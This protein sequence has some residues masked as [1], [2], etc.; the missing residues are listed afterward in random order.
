MGGV[1]LVLHHASWYNHFGSG[2]AASFRGNRVEDTM[3]FD[4]SLLRLDCGQRGLDQPLDLLHGT[5][6]GLGWVVYPTQETIPRHQDCSFRLGIASIRLLAYGRLQLGGH[7]SLHSRHEESTNWSACGV[8]SRKYTYFEC[9]N[10]S[11]VVSLCQQVSNVSL[12]ILA[13]IK[14]QIASS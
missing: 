3:K 1:S 14:M 11:M 13:D 2:N 9:Q 6:I 7:T 5:I 12:P 10:E 8:P 4:W